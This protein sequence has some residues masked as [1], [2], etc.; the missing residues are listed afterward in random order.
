MVKQADILILDEAISAVDDKTEDMALEMINL[1]CPN[2]T[3]IV[4][5]H[6]GMGIKLCN[7][8][9]IIDKQ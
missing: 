9:I 2:S 3:I 6:H 4:I 8:S 5:A 7:R 1:L